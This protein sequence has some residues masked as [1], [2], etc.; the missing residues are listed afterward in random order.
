MSIRLREDLAASLAAEAR[1]K[2]HASLNAYVNEI[3]R[4]HLFER[5]GVSWKRTELERKKA[6]GQVL[7]FHVQD[8]ALPRSVYGTRIQAEQIWG[9]VKDVNETMVFIAYEVQR[10]LQ[11]IL[12]VPLESIQGWEDLQIC[13]EDLEASK[14]IQAWL[15]ENQLENSKRLGQRG[16]NLDPHRFNAPY[17]STHAAIYRMTNQ[18]GSPPASMQGIT[19]FGV[20]GYGP[21]IPPFE[22]VTEAED[23]ARLEMILH[24]RALRIPMISKIQHKAVGLDDALKELGLP[25]QD[26]RLTPNGEPGLHHIEFS[27][28]PWEDLGS[29]FQPTASRKAFA[30][31]SFVIV[32]FEVTSGAD[33]WIDDFRIGGSPNLL[34]MGQETWVPVKRGTTVT[35]TKLAAQA[36]LVKPNVVYVEGKIYVHDTRS[37]HVEVQALVVPL[38]DEALLRRNA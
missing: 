6:S 24:G 36:I 35:H 4:Q 21:S 22:Y 13:P 25:H 30:N 31:D 23:R 8:D 2:G 1:G 7:C 28:V 29:E 16:S 9:T 17:T 26:S 34:W 27:M 32:G 38:G 3:C 14:H 18:G 5:G 10:N 19:G 20:V 12:K 11:D 33:L 15:V 37:T